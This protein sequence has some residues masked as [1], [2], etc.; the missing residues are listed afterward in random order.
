MGV[1]YNLQDQ[2]YFKPNYIRCDLLIY[3]RSRIS[4]PIHC[5]AH[6]HISGDL[7]KIYAM[8]AIPKSVAIEIHLEFFGF[9]PI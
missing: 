8:T 4:L 5:V 6:E 2:F 9:F 7:F 3:I 1:G